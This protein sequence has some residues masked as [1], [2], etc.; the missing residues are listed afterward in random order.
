MVLKNNIVAIE[1]KWFTSASSRGSSEQKIHWSKI[2]KNTARGD[3]LFIYFQMMNLK[4]KESWK[5]NYRYQ[6]LSFELGTWKADFLSVSPMNIIWIFFKSG[7]HNMRHSFISKKHFLICFFGLLCDP[8]M[9]KIHI[10]PV[11]LMD[12][13]WRHGQKNQLF[14]YQV[15]NLEIDIYNL[16]FM[17]L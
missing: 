16:F 3:F 12:H 6:F 5:T 17:N 13:F 10:I 9:K 1:I 15:Q 7:S 14:T 8:D 11:P 2:N 4:L